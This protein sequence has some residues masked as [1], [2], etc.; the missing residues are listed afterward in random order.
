M[1]DLGPGWIL[2]D[3][4]IKQLRTQKLNVS[5]HQLLRWRD[6]GLLPRPKRVGRGRSRGGSDSYYPRLA[7]LQAA[8]IATRME[9]E[10]KLG[11]KPKLAE[12]GWA[13]WVL[14][15]PVTDFAR[16]LL[17]GDLADAQYLLREFKRAPQET[18]KLIERALNSKNPVFRSIRDLV[19]NP[20][21]AFPMLFN[22]MSGDLQANQHSVDDWI[23]FQ[24]TTAVG[25][26]RDALFEEDLPSPEEFAIGIQQIAQTQN[27]GAVIEKLENTENKS[28]RI[29]CNEA[30]HIFAMLAQGMN[31]GSV[32]MPPDYFLHYFK[33]RVLNPDGAK[34]IKEL[35]RG[36]GWTKPPLSEFEKILVRAGILPEVTPEKRTRKS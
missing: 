23:S 5:N 14:G 15:F 10:R 18:K 19:V 16:D 28:L 31:L 6:A 17:L 30:Q 4:M 20:A 2:R 36:L 32:L 1:M 12:V 9:Q 22:M 3:D 13:L 29:Y 11:R 25:L 35:I 27:T 8:E 24:E 34:S 26:H 21:A 7:L 33:Q